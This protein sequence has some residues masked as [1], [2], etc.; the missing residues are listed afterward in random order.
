MHHHARDFLV[1]LS[2]DVQRILA[3]RVGDVEVGLTELEQVGSALDVAGADSDMERGAALSIPRLN[4]FL[5]PVAWLKAATGAGCWLE[6]VVM[7]PTT[8][9]APRLGPRLL[10]LGGSLLARSARS[11]VYCSDVRALIPPAQAIPRR[12][13]A[14]TMLHQHARDFLVVLLRD[15]QRV[16]ASTVG[17]VDVDLNELEQVGSAVD[18]A[19]A[20]SDMERVSALS[21]PLLNAFCG[22]WLG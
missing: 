13:L 16:L 9:R 22:P 8:A 5:W 15:V 6:A 18:V 1:V 10:P 19:G 12:T 4:A 2:R 20:D 11:L 3:S 14:S 17:Y 21:I 7:Q